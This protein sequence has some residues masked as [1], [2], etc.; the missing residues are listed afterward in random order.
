MRRV[1]G[2]QGEGCRGDDD[3]IQEATQGIT[4][5]SYLLFGTPPWIKATSVDVPPISRVSTFLYP[6]FSAIHRA[7]VTPPAGPL[8][9]RLTGNLVALSSEDRPMRTDPK[10]HNP[11]H[12]M[13][14]TNLA[15]SK[16]P[17]LVYLPPSDL[18]IESL[19]PPTARVTF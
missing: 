5:L 6:I 13:L 8:I 1:Q 15:P 19:V 2:Q 4:A 18:R 14:K 9:R 10:Q 3:E 11:S 17:S 16:P 12:F 7:P